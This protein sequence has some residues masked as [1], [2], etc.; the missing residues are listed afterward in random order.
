MAGLLYLTKSVEYMS[1]GSTRRG[2]GSRRLPIYMMGRMLDPNFP[3]TILGRIQS[4]RIGWAGPVAMTTART[5][6]T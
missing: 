2:F 4:G 1:F 3:P 5:G 6:E